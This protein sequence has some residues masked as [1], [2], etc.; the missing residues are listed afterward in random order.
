MCLDALERLLPD[1]TLEALEMILDQN[2]FTPFT[3]LKRGNQLV[4]LIENWNSIYY[5][6]RAYI[7]D[8]HL[9]LF[10]SVK[11]MSKITKHSIF[12]LID[13]SEMFQR[14]DIKP[15]ISN[16]IVEFLFYSNVRN[17]L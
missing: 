15:S 14:F 8:K 6:I 4:F 1:I 7:E 10:N 12:N 5:C 2:D 17:L 16:M 9:S 13:Q 3:D 11:Y